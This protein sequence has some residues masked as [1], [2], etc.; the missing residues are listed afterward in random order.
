MNKKCN[1]CPHIQPIEDYYTNPR[2]GKQSFYCRKCK[3]EIDNLGYQR[4]REKRLKEC[5]AYREANRV[6]I[7]EYFR[8]RKANATPE[9]RVVWSEKARIYRE[10]QL[11]RAKRRRWAKKL[12]DEVL[13][14]YGGAACKC[15]GETE[16]DLLTLDHK[17]D[18]GAEHRRTVARHKNIY[19]WARQHGYP[20]IFDV[21][22]FNCN[23]GRYRSG[24]GICPHEIT[25]QN[26]MA[27][28][29]ET[30][31]YHAA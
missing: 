23:C 27:A 17:F 11:T 9:Q 19:Q 21:M 18:D 29:T 13:E 12:R 1:R 6:T 26:L 15:C 14:H 20:P 24:L 4:H 30:S 5:A 10:H 2:T 28:A 25:R 22:C 7:N 8:E 31:A 16:L 3:R